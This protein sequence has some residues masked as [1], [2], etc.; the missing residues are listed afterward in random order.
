METQILGKRIKELR[1]KLELTQKEFTN[2]LSITSATLSAYEKNTVNPSISVIAEIAEKYNVSVDWLLGLS[3]NT[4]IA[5]LKNYSDVLQNIFQLAISLNDL[6]FDFEGVTI[7]ENEEFKTDT[8]IS[9]ND[10]SLA[11]L[12][13]KFNK[14]YI[15]YKNQTI[16]ID[17]LQAVVESLK[18]E[19]KNKEI[20]F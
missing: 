14:T 16:D 20:G 9:I 3:D 15:L 18:K 8:Y 10:S 1:Q 2:E 13:D 4:S 12:L 11:F 6:E 5:K 17:V 7:D 19:C